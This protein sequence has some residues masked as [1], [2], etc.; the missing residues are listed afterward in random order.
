[1]III[2]SE[3]EIKIIREGGKILAE[4]LKRVG[5]MAKPGITTLD[6]DRAAEAL[7]L[8]AGAKPG[9]KGHEGFPY[10]LCASVNEN[11]VHGYPSNYVLK[12]G[13]IVGLDL[14]VVYKGFNT[15]MAITVPVG[16]VSFEAKRLINVTKKS[17][18]LGIKKAKIGN[19]IGDI[20][21][22]VQRF[23][24]DQGF[25]VVRDLCGHGI[26]KELHEDPKIP[27]FGKRGGGEKLVEGMVICIEPMVTAGEYHLRNSDDGYGF[28]TKDNSL[29]AHFEHTIAI[30]KKGPRILTEI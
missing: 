2:K 28:A 26:G 7:I 10:S 25:S 12:N 27:N 22:T 3:E 14:G 13:D 1:M 24:E 29:S 23:V 16:E 17:L 21:N 9:F 11:I 19:T 20:G 6:L 8:V 15:D 4:V 18:R 30:T 5:E